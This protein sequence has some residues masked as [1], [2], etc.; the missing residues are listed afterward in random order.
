MRPCLIKREM[1]LFLH[2]KTSILV[3]FYHD[4]H[5]YG[6]TYGGNYCIHLYIYNMYIINRGMIMEK[7][8]LIIE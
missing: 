8:A 7:F 5:E 4:S 2:K 1:G 6:Y 3:L